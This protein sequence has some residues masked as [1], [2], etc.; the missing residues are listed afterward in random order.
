MIHAENRLAPRMVL[1]ITNHEYRR[2]LEQTFQNFRIPIYYQCQGHGT[3]PSEMLDIFGLSGSGRLLTIGLLP[4]FL[5]RDLLDA[6]VKLRDGKKATD[7]DMGFM[8]K[9]AVKKAL[10]KIEGTDIEKLLKEYGVI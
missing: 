8:E 10:G 3:A 7:M 6:T 4:K 1:I 9:M 2:K 5:V